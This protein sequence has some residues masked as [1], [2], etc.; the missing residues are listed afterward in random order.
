MI[1]KLIVVCSFFTASF[2]TCF[3]M[4]TLFCHAN[5]TQELQELNSKIDRIVIF[6]DLDLNAEDEVEE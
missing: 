5:I 1:N 2:V 6:L 4:T 3:L